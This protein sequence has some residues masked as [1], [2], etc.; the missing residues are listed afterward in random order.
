MA[1]MLARRCTGP[2]GVVAARRRIDAVAAGVAGVRRRGI[3]GAA[4]I[5]MARRH[6]DGGVL[7]TGKILRI[8]FHGRGRA[9]AAQS[10]NASDKKLSGHGDYH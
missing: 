5:F 4:V 8:H 9:H 3:A 1:G 7:A 6:I 10:E 2:A